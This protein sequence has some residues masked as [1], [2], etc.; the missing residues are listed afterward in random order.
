VQY[1]QQAAQNALQRY[2]YQEAIGHFR[3]G[4]ALVPQLP[5]TPVR[6]RQELD[7][8]IGLG[9]ALH[10]VQGQTSPEVEQAY[11]R[12]RELCQQVGETP[13]LLA[14]LQ[15]L[16]WFYSARAEH[17]TACEVGEQ[18]LRLAQDVQEPALLLEAH[19]SLGLSRC[20]L[21]EFVRAREHLEHG[22]AVYER[23]PCEICAVSQVH[24]AGAVCLT[25]AARVLWVL[26]YPEQALTQSLR[27]VACAREC[28]GPYT[29]AHT[30]YFAAALCQFRRDTHLAHE[31]LDALMGLDAE[32]GFPLYAACG[33]VL[34]GW[35]RV[36]AGQGAEGIAQMRQG[37]TALQAM[38]VGASWP[39]MLALL[40]EAYGKMG[41]GEAGLRV[42][43]DAL[44][45]V[46]STGERFYEA[47]I[48][49]LQGALLLQRAVPDTLQAE[50]CLQHAL[51]IVRG[52]QAKSFELRA[53]LSLS[54]LWQQQ[55]KRA[56]AHALL[57]PIYGWFTEGFD[58]AD[59]QEAKALLEELP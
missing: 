20:F 13:Q 10:A 26:G 23:Q 29:L 9:S 48:Y 21:G 18:L 56:E 58:T 51:E 28:A 37:L 11:S 22:I 44:A 52:Q 55:G 15:G 25:Y 53:A 39:Y 40:A 57:A 54:Q 2:A 19:Q 31:W 45:A 33:T 36:A 1:L 46:Q 14:V 47:E 8:Q 24:D 34:R 3:R 30:L 42:L 7:L 17:Q 50:R 16:R 59:L 4:V 43:A 12:A 32:Q 41:Q 35:L 27:A 5:E 6:L 49:R 38:R